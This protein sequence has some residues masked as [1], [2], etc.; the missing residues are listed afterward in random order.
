MI[1]PGF[2]DVRDAY[3]RL[4]A[5]G[6]PLVALEGAVDW[7]GLDTLMSG[8]V[9][10][11]D[12]KG[13]KGGRKPFSG[14]MMAKILILQACNNLSDDRTEFLINDRLSFKRFLGLEL[15]EKSPDAKT[16][17]LWR[18]RVMHSGLHAKIFAWFERE[19]VRHGFE[20]KGGQIVD[21][22]FVPTHKPTGKHRKHLAEAVPLSAAQARQIDADATF[23]KKGEATHHGY[24]N[25]ANVDAKWKLIREAEITP[26]APHDSTEFAHLVREGKPGESED[27]RRVWGDSA[28]RSE[29]AEA[30][31]A[32]KNLLSE[33]HERA[34]RNR[35]LT[36]A[37]KAANRLKSSVRVRIEHV[38]G[39]METAMGGMMIHTLGLAR[40]RVKITFKNLA[41]NLQRFVFLTTRR[42]QEKCA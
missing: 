42:R 4:D 19:L 16:I 3:A 6:D 41:Y 37:Q 31:L 13:G 24:K 33:V 40:A 32:Q 9:F 27:N 39:H 22:T 12:G 29:A 20:A 5:V 28:Y 2:F 35:P 21:A 14:L 7:S 8:V 11:R 26:N 15:R 10:E 34:Y 38:F 36:E 18:E 30:M 1:Q 23:T 25:H 17:W